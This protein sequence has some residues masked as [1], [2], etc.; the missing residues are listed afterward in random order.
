MPIE[1]HPSVTE[2]EGSTVICR[3]V[4]LWKFYDFFANEELYFRRTDLFKETDSSEGLPSD[5]YVRKIYGLRPGVIEDELKLNEQQAFAR[6][7]SEACFINCWQIFE[8]ETLHM[9][10]TYGQGGGILVFSTFQRL[11]DAVDAFIDQIIIGKVKYNEEGKRG[12][13]LIDHLFTKRSH[14]DREK[15][16]R[17]VLTSY[18]PM[19]GLNRNFDENGIPRRE[20]LDH[21]YPLPKWVHEFKRRRIDL[22]KLITGIR[23]SPYVTYAQREDIG[24]WKKNKNMDCNLDESELAGMLTPTPDEM[25][26]IAAKRFCQQLFASCGRS[27]LFCSCAA[28]EACTESIAPRVFFWKISC[29]AQVRQRNHMSGKSANHQFERRCD[30]SGISRGTVARHRE[31]RPTGRR[32]GGHLSAPPFLMVSERW[33]STERLR[34]VAVHNSI[35]SFGGAIDANTK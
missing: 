16:I 30:N 25:K 13:N 12:D 21:L 5:D 20:P 32:K 15:E 27:A 2:P 35:F 24:W 19:A 28:V 11:R 14:F 26:N 1:P 33:I 18:N 3:F 17:V 7:Y 6:Q 4:E 34:H 8:G 31:L 29:A 23:F 10:N 22:K 9:W